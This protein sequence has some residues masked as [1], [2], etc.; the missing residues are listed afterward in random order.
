M[1]NI[2]ILFYHYSIIMSTK[3]TKDQEDIL[4]TTKGTIPGYKIVELKGVLYHDT[5]GNY[6][7]YLMRDAKKRYIKD[8]TRKYGIIDVNI[9]KSTGKYNSC[10]T[11]GTLVTLEREEGMMDRV[12][13]TFDK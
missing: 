10:I 2:S 8:D 5:C 12:R 13:S 9:K 7:E 1:K 11:T 4:N 3:E 6:I